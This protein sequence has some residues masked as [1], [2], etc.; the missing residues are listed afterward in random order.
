M[1]PQSSKTQ[2]PKKYGKNAKLPETNSK[3]E[4]KRIMEQ[5]IEQLLQ[6]Q[7]REHSV[8]VNKV[9]V[10]KL[11]GHCVK[12]GEAPR[13]DGGYAELSSKYNKLIR[14]RR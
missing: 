2:T 11:A 13:K 10:Q 9:G 1:L 5:H 14:L 7:Q 12:S 4:A 8:S 6:Q 3:E